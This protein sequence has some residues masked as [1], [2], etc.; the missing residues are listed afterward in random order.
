VN[1]QNLQEAVVTYIQLK[2]KG[3][4]YC[5]SAGGLRTSISQASAMKRAGYVKGVPDL[6]IMEARHNYYGLFMEIK[7][8]KGRLSPH[9]KQWLEDLNNKGYLAKCCYG[10]EEALDIID[11]YLK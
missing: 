11:W 7:T 6:Q 3:V 5:A 2:H 8:K 10:L 1:E 9:Q 4:R